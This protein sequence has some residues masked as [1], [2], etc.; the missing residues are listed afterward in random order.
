M[1]K[2]DGVAMNAI[3]FN[4]TRGESHRDQ[5]FN[6]NNNNKNVVFIQVRFPESIEWHI[7]TTN[8]VLKEM[9]DITFK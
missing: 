7:L 9:K 4:P 3:H 1:K 5:I 6:N 8:A 2:D